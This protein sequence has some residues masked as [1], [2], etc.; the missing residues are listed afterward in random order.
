VLCSCSR[1]VGL[2][3][4]FLLPSLVAYIDTAGRPA[5]EGTGMMT[6]YQGRQTVPA[7]DVKPGTVHI[8]CKYLRPNYDQIAA[9]G[10]TTTV[11][12]WFQPLVVG[13]QS[14]FIVDI[15]IK[16]KYRIQY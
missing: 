7:R 4:T 10:R 3:N 12:P 5:R 11:I 6:M 2:P 15:G 1:V 14:I 16:E 13:C 8:H 9:Y